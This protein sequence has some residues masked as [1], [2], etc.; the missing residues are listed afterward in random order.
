M[1]FHV[2][3]PARYGSTR[4]P[5]KVL[6]DIHGRPMLQYVYDNARASGATRVVVAT[7][8]ERVA[9]ACRDFG[10]EVCMTSADHR[11]G[12]D[13]LAE[14]AEVLGLADDA[15]VVNV[16]GDEPLLPWQ[17]IH[18]VADDLVAHGDAHVA[19]LCEPVR[20]AEELFD[21]NAVKVV[22]DGA[23]YALY[24]S[25][26]PIPWHRDGFSA[27]ERRLPPGGSHYRHLGLYAY[28]VSYLK[29]FAT[30][31]PC[32]L[33]RLESLEQLR[34]LHGGHRIH[35]AAALMAPGMGVDTPG[36]L[37]RVRG[38]VRGRGEWGIVNSE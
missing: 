12:T 14:A 17:L 22:M 8:S 13:R 32:E 27:A 15:V 6:A 36:D 26:A 34:A 31:P 30:H 19:T 4:L 29:F 25:R 21:A 1:T 20:S 2:I 16:Q 10:A 37:A 5:G 33:E 11:T 9:E 24:F 7:D 35:V 38:M 23:G 28:R 18:Q 3:I